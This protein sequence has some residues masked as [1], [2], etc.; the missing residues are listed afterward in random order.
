M[1]D[2]L[3]RSGSK[4]ERHS[5]SRSQPP[6]HSSRHRRC[7]D[8]DPRIESYYSPSSDLGF[9]DTYITEPQVFQDKELHQQQQELADTQERAA[10]ANSRAYEEAIRIAA[11][12]KAQ[13]EATAEALRL[14]VQDLTERLASTSKEVDK[15]EY[16]AEE[17][18]TQRQRERE[19]LRS[20]S[21]GAEVAAT[22]ARTE[23]ESEIRHLTMR[24]KQAEAKARMAESRVL[25]L[26]ERLQA[27]EY[28]YQQ[29]EE[30]LHETLVEVERLRRQYKHAGC[31]AEGF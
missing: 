7:G 29:S 27:Y 5:Y 2:T 4:T 22:E 11:T 19:I 20:K 16:Q 14:E 15:L 10:E 21:R 3:R 6:S 12:E 30:R 25:E 28:N 9:H 18:R 26:E 1:S 24:V 23:H 13:A 8:R 31:D 17:F